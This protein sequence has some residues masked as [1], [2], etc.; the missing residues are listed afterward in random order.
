MTMGEDVFVLRRVHHNNA[1]GAFAVF[2]SVGIHV[3]SNRCL[4]PPMP[5]SS[6][7]SAVASMGESSVLTNA[8][9]SL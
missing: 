3:Q 5:P 7:G 2:M 1:D 4:P 6:S 9:A 8:H